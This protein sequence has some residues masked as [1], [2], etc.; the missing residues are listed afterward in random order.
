MAVGNSYN[1][2][3]FK[4]RFAKHKELLRR[5]AS[6]EQPPASGPCAL[7]G[8]PEVEVEYHDEDYSFPYRWSEPAVYVL[9]RHCH[10]HKLHMKFARPVQWQAYL[11]HVRRGGYARD[12]KDPLIKKEFE[13]CC[14]AIEKGQTYVLG[15][16]RPY[17]RKIGE[18][19]FAGLRLDRESLTDPSIPPLP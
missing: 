6:G 11:A 1:G 19:W 9:C 10:R 3:S 16:L 12:L 8:D 18:E 15:K 2:Y 17:T 5:L 4:E 13:A 14:K 7:C